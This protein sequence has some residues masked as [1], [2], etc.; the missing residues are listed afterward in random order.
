M[1]TE[2][3]AE[4]PQYLVREPFFMEP[5][6]LKPGHKIEFEGSPGPHLTPLNQSAHDAMEKWYMEEVDEVDDHGKKTGSKITP[7]EQWRFLTPKASA[8]I[9]DRPRGTILSEPPRSITGVENTLAGASMQRKLGEMRPPP[10]PFSEQ[11]FVSA[12]EG[13]IANAATGRRR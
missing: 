1:E 3:I 9:S 5:W 4:V 6:L 13:L 12:G 7:H 8:E 11:P 10:A 2:V